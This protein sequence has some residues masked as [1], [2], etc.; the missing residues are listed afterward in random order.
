MSQKTV[1]HN[2][3]GGL[4]SYGHVAGILMSDSTI[5]RIP[6]DPGHAETF[7]FP[8]IYHTLEGF[9][10]EDLVEIRKDHLDV[11]LAGA[12]FLEDKGVRFAAADCGLFGPFTRDVTQHLSIP[13]I[14]TALD[15]VPLLQHHLPARQ[16]TGIITGDTRILKPA[17]LDASGIDPDSVVISGM[18]NSDAFRQVVMERGNI[19]DVSHMR[20]GV[21]QAAEALK[22]QNIGA[23]VLEC[24]NLISFKTD[25]Q[26]CLRL[27]VFDLTSLIEFYAA[28]FMRQAFTSRFI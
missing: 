27:P 13:F 21:I 20:S 10:F 24:T 7:S 23:V 6:G 15:L 16:K 25:I 2:V 12:K 9:P 28:G 1:S 18:E 3:T 8:V 11:L 14:G 19:L 26:G 17:H 4:T 22:D 5:P